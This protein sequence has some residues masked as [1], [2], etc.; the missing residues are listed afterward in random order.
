MNISEPRVLVLDDEEVIRIS[1][2]A[3]LEDE[4]FEVFSADSGESGLKLLNSEKMD[5]GI[6][7]IRL[8][9]MDGAEFILKAVKIQ[10]EMKFLIYTGSTD[11]TLPKSL[12]ILGITE[13]YLFRKPLSDMSVLAEAVSELL[14]THEAQ[15]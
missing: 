13:K 9:G 14:M 10:P 2:E 15:S 6:I 4:G 5:A 12:Q 7:D 1:L 8:P 11:F 3:F